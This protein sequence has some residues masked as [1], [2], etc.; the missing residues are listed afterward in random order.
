MTEKEYD[1]CPVCENREFF[2]VSVSSTD[3]FTSLISCGLGRVTL[4]VCSKCGCVY[5]GKEKLK[6]YENF[7]R[8]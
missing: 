3:G 2:S 6:Q 4:Y 8:R 5:V 7:K 1:R